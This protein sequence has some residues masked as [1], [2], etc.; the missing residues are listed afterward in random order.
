MK[1]LTLT[2]QG[3]NSFEESVCIDFCKLTSRG[4]FGIFG[5]T[6]SGKSSILDGMTLAL[7]G[8]AARGTKNFINVNSQRCSVIF[9]FLAGPGGRERYR[10]SRNY[11]REKETGSARAS[12]ARLE[13]IGP[14]GQSEILAD[15]TRNV[16]EECIRILGLGR[17]DFLRTAVLP[18]GRFA[19]FLR[20]QGK[21]RTEMLERIFGLERFGTLLENVSGI[22][23]RK[24]ISGFRFWKENGRFI[25]GLQKKRWERRSAFW[26]R[27][28]GRRRRQRR[29]SSG[30]RRIWKPGSRYWMPRQS[31]PGPWREAAL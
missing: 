9:E 3:L 30:Y 2:I 12:L 17:E 8:E 18:Q 5:P 29:K 4:L 1:P 10:V 26:R 11:R 22:S 15:Q 25:R 19:E 7:Y 21:E 31:F 14:E 6:G 28:S 13:K 27:K 16:N 23:D 24:R 20:M